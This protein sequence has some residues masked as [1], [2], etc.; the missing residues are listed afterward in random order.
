[1]PLVLTGWISVVHIICF[2]FGVTETRVSLLSRL[3]VAL[4]WEEPHKILQSV[5]RQY[6]AN[7]AM[8]AYSPPLYANVA[9]TTL[10]RKSASPSFLQTQWHQHQETAMKAVVNSVAPS[11]QNKH[12]DTHTPTHNQ[13]TDKLPNVPK[14]GLFN[15]LF[16]GA[17]DIL[18]WGLL[19]G[20]VL[21][22][23][24]MCWPGWKMV[25]G[26]DLQ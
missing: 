15:T 12:W 11:R 17:C 3:T 22:E 16:P 1:M 19:T 5:F 7:L 14:T 24:T 20:L 25:Y 10:Q 4:R 8:L 2:F 18:V 13:Y 23:V 9:N 21:W 26:K 6:S